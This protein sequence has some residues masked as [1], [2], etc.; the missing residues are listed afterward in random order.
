MYLKNGIRKTPTRKIPIRNIPT[1]K[2]PPWNI[3]THVFKYSHSS[4]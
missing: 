3:P 1:H 4:F 2:T